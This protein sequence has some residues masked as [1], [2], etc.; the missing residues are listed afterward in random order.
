MLTALE[1]KLDPANAALLTIDVQN[2]C[3]SPE[4]AP[5]KFHGRDVSMHIKMIDGI[6]ALVDAARR[7]GVPIVHIRREEAPWAISEPMK[8]LRLRQQARRGVGLPS[9]DYVLG[10]EGSSG[11]DFYRL[12]P[13]PQDVIVTKH[14]YSGFVGTNLDI[15][16]RS[17]NR[18][19]LI[20]CGGSTNIC[21]ESTVRDAF[22]RDYFCVV[23][24]DCSPTPWGEEAY[25]GALRN[26]EI[27][28]GQVIT[29][30]EALA[31]WERT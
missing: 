24:A 16:L 21:L 15:I 17:S 29:L 28:F 30:K 25:K 14:R 2:D 22:M 27:A 13:E 4:A 8:E 31:V 20:F 7:A 3:C 23:V 1:E 26:I 18:K 19:S 5:A 11:A 12:K 9:L 10:A 6:L